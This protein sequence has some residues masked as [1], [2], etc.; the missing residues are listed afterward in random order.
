M[1]RDEPAL[2]TV[3]HQYMARTLAIKVVDTNRLVGALNQ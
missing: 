3:F 1:Q 2:A